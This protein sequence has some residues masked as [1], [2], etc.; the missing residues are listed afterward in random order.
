[1]RAAD[2]DLIELS[3]VLVDAKNT[4]VADMVVSASIHATG[5]IDGDVTDVEQVIKIIKT[6]LNRFRDRDRLGIG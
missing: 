4:D 1:M 3:P 6:A 2:G 5:N